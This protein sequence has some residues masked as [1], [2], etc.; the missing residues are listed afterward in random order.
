MDETYSL[1][2]V[3][4]ITFLTLVNLE[5]GINM[6]TPYPK[7]LLNL[8]AEPWMRLIVYVTIYILAC[9]NRLLALMLA[10]FVLLLHLDYINLR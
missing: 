5:Y 1:I 6:T 2:T 10:M 7:P 3:A 4:I 8:F 9:Y